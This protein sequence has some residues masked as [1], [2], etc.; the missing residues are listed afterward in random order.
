MNTKAKSNSIVTTTVTDLSIAFHV[1]GAGT[2]ILSRSAISSTVTVRAMLHG[3]IQRVSDAAAKSRD[4]TTGLPATPEAK[5]AAM[6]RLVD[7]YNSGS[8][9]WSPAR[10]EGVVALDTI[11]VRAIMEVL[12]KD[13]ATVRAYIDRGA[14]KNGVTP[15][16]YL[17]KVGTGEKVSAVADRMRGESLPNIDADDEL[18]GMDDEE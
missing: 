1:K 10:V 17:A 12:G 14:T 2:C 13:E 15:R 16:A 7:H 18:E 11:L 6:S 9:E 4:T 5:L 3:L 8:E